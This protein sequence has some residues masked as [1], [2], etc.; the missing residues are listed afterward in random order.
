MTRPVSP[1]RVGPE[2]LRRAT[3]ARGRTGRGARWCQRVFG[4]RRQAIEGFR[5]TLILLGEM[6]NAKLVA[7]PDANGPVDH[8]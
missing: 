4:T 5:D 7:G 8:G 6:R 3:Q 2:R 1:G